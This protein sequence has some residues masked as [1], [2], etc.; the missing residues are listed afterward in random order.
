MSSLVVWM[1][2]TVKQRVCCTKMDLGVM[3]FHHQE[4]KLH[5]LR[6]SLLL[7]D[8]FQ[9]FFFGVK[10]GSYCFGSFVKILERV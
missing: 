9:I 4:I 8:S 2:I 6:C 1:Q 5:C 3:K 10:S 7:I